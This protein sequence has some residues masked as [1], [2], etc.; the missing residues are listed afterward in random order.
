MCVPCV[1]DIGVQ[2][3]IFVPKSERETEGGMNRYYEELHNWSSVCILKMVKPL[4]MR[5]TGAIA[6][7]WGNW[8]MLTKFS[9]EDL[10]GR[11]HTCD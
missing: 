10:T 3:G 1:F 9:S 4:K 11:A 7:V 8:G 5:M 2:R 6:H